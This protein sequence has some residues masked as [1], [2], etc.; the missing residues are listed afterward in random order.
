MITKE[1]I[2]LFRVSF[3]SFTAKVPAVLDD[4]Q[5][6]ADALASSQGKV[7]ELESVLD[8]MNIANQ[9]LRDANSA[10]DARVAALIRELAA[11][12]HLLGTIANAVQSAQPVQD[13][14][15]S[16]QPRAKQI[17][18]TSSRSSTMLADLQ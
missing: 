13:A 5:A 11:K 8:A 12:D 10:L 17:D 7:K 15:A 4:M 18:G 16:L 1:T 3:A 14:I 2:D 9:D 6:T